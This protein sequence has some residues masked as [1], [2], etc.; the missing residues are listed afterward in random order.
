V[1]AIYASSYRFA[2]PPAMPRLTALADDGKVYLSWDDRA[3]KA[4][5]EPMLSG[6]N[7]FEGYKLYKATDKHFKD[8]EV[9]QDPFGNPAG[10]KPIF[11]CDLVDSIVGFPEQAYYNGIGYYVGDDAGIQH[12]FIDNDVQNGRT[13]YYGLVAYDYG[14]K[15]AGAF[16][17]MV[18]PTENTVVIDLDENENIR[19]TGINVQVATPHQ[20][21]AGYTVPQMTFIDPEN[22]LSNGTIQSD[23]F[24]PDSIKSNHMYKIKFQTDTVAHSTKD[25]SV[26]P[27]KRDGFISTVGYSILDATLND[28]LLF[29]ETRAKHIPQNWDTTVAL[30]TITSVRDTL[31]YTRPS[32]SKGLS[33]EIIDGMRFSINPNSDVP[34]LDNLRSGWQTGSVPIEIKLNPR[35]ST[36]FAYDYNIIFIDTLLEPAHVTTIERKSTPYSITG[37]DDNDAYIGPRVLLGKSFPFQ[38]INRSYPDSTV[39][40][41]KGYE[42]LDMTVDDENRNGRFD[43][44]SDYV[45]VSY[46]IP[47]NGRIYSAGT[48]F[49]IRFPN[50]M[51][52]PGDVYRVRFNSAMKDSVMFS[53]NVTSTADLSKL[54]EDMKRIKVVPNPYIVTNTM[55]S[56]ISNPGYN[57]RRILLFTHIPAQSTIKIFTSSGVFIRQLDIENP[58]DDGTYHWDMLTKEGLEIAAGIYVYQVK[59]KT[60]GVEQFGKFAVIK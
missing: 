6:A 1:K 53:M 44:D 3:E 14:F 41:Y 22:V 11:Q 18:P 31:Y 25:F 13:Y 50:G 36:Y 10:K 4:T 7:D 39:L 57:Q 32:S 38:V 37:L 33:S 5:R 60:T 21:A 12:S 51:P 16:G 30:Y 46:T 54:K 34:A 55:E 23:I 27:H 2:Q 24:R 52:R 28:K 59:S 8:A 45:L 40:G 47:Y 58:A 48:I 56:Y 20:H 19:S 17:V 29:Q 15:S 9:V 43:P 42:Q 49:G 35:R 26:V